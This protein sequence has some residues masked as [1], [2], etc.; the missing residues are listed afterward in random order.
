MASRTYQLCTCS[1]AG[2][3]TQAEPTSDTSSWRNHGE[4]CGL[5]EGEDPHPVDTIPVIGVPVA[6]WLYSDAVA[7]RPPSPCKERPAAPLVVRTM[8]AEHTNTQ[9]PPPHEGD[10]SKRRSMSDY[11]E[12][13]LTEELETLDKVEDSHWTTVVHRCAWEYFEKS[14]RNIKH[15]TAKQLDTVSKPTTDMTTAQKQKIQQWQEK[16]IPRRESSSL[17]WGEGPSKPKEKGIDNWR[18][19]C[20]SLNQNVR[21]EL[22]NIG[23]NLT[24]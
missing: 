23:K 11:K 3:V 14:F 17:T 4:D 20:L 13:V 8:V 24:H 19:S 7:S 18:W 1:R 6:I 10:A 22:I 9:N 15:L 21:I 5:S 16:V 12:Q 2:L